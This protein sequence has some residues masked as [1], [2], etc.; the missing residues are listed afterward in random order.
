MIQG[1]VGLTVPA[2]SDNVG[3]TPAQ[4]GALGAS[5]LGDRLLPAP[6]APIVR[7]L[8]LGG[9]HLP[10]PNESLSMIRL[11]A[12]P[13]PVEDGFCASDVYTVVF[14]DGSLKAPISETTPLRPVRV[15]V[16][17]FYQVEAGRVLGRPTCGSAEIAF[18]IQPT[19]KARQL[20]V[21]R[22]LVRAQHLAQGGSRLPFRLTQSAE[23]RRPHSQGAVRPALAKLALGEIVSVMPTAYGELTAAQRADAAAGRPGALP[24]TAAIWLAGGRSVRLTLSGDTLTGIYLDLAPRR[25]AYPLASSSYPSRA[26]HPST[27]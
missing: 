17:T 19:S 7:R 14:N 12:E 10:P 15:G 16:D 8:P 21:V 3:L 24:D 9:F 20:F 18:A 22:L 2:A 26:A 5:E 4:V 13:L 23:A 6:H 27:P 25:E 11:Q 1:A